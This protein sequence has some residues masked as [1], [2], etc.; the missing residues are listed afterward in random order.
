MTARADLADFGAFYE[1]T[2][3][4]AYR[5]AYA[6]VGEPALAA[7]AVQDAYLSAFRERARFRGDGS[8]EA[9]L[10][11]IV[12]NAAITASRRRRVRWVEPLPLVLVAP[13]DE[14]LRSVER[15]TVVAALQ[16]LP[17][18]ERAAVV[19]RFYHDYDYATIA[20]CLN[21]STGTVGS[22]LSRAMARLRLGLTGPA[23]IGPRSG[24]SEGRD[25][26]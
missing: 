14:P 4:T 5:T 19:L 18:K 11:R 26:S 21:T 10:I 8:V 16:A 25:G 9:W 12:V 20:R 17:P 2:Y 6:I 7:D 23:E 24:G 13:G 22:W 15:L 3:A 1:R